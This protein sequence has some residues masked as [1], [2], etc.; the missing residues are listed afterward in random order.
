MNTESMNATLRFEEF[1]RFMLDVEWIVADLGVPL[2]I[3][4]ASEGSINL[5]Y[6][7]NGNDAIIIDV[8]ISKWGANEYIVTAART[9]QRYGDKEKHDNHE[10][11]GVTITKHRIETK[12]A[13]NPETERPWTEYDLDESFIAELKGMYSVDTEEDKAYRISGEK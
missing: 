1:K 3:K 2:H 11:Y 9:E 5:W 12:I 8:M 6:R 10:H 7:V 13:I 4:T